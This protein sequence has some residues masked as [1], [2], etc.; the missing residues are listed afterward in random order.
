MYVQFRLFRVYQESTF[1][2]CKLFLE[3]AFVGHTN[4]TP[5]WGSNPWHAAYNWFDGVTLS[6]G[7]C[8]IQ[9]IT[10]NCLNWK[11]TFCRKNRNKLVWNRGQR[12]VWYKNTRYLFRIA[13]ELSEKFITKFEYNFY[14][15]IS[16]TKRL[17]QLNKSSTA[18]LVTENVKICWKSVGINDLYTRR[19][20]KGKNQC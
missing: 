9:Y 3:Q 15:K 8:S 18:F 6:L 20:D 11:V 13:V 2:R 1:V 19:I 5:T 16:T 17:A 10:V 14:L 7:Y 12:L 4:V